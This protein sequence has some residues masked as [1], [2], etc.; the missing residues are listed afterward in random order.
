MNKPKITKTITMFVDYPEEGFL[1]SQVYTDNLSSNLKKFFFV[2]QY[3]PLNKLSKKLGYF[4]LKTRFLFRYFIYPLFAPFHQGEI[5]HIIDQTYAHL[6]YF[7]DGEK[8]V[9]TVHDLDVLRLKFIKWPTLRDKIMKYFYIWSVKALKKAAK[10]IAV[11]EDTKKD[12]VRFL[13]IPE[14]KIIVIP[15]GADS[16]F[17]RMK[18]KKKLKLVKNKYKLPEKFILHAGECWKYKN[19]EGILKIFGKISEKKDSKNLF[20]VKV[21]GT[22]S[23]EQ[24]KLIEK[25]G[26]GKRIVKLPFVPPQDL[27]AIYNQA[28]VLLQLSF[29]EGF[30]LTVL[31]AMSCGCPVVVSDAPALKE[32]V[33]D[34]G[35]I[36]NPLEEEKV[37][38]ELRKMIL[39]KKIR[40]IYIKKGLKRAK[41][42]SWEKTARKTLK[43]YEEIIAKKI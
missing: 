43:V 16:V 23:E 33:N 34:S 11:S 42:F 3:L 39:N 12:I 22:W 6:L 25:L 41:E 31:E 28:A 30:G 13:Q 37:I 21:N 5:N 18:D 9:V 36:V 17:K 40:N 24:R 10:I 38:T 32:L 27:A 26:I 2:D 29:L 8:T 19:I 15:E 35:I 14:E 4:N 1:S 7:L 20:F